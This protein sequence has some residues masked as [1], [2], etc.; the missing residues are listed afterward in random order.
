MLFAPMLLIMLAQSMPETAFEVDLWPGEGRPVFAASAARLQLREAPAESAGVAATWTGRIGQVLA[1]DDTRYRTVEVGRFVVLSP[2]TLTGR[3]L[4]DTRRLSREDY[5]SGTFGPARVSLRA[6]DQV[7]YLQYRAEGTCFVRVG[8]AA[9]E[10]DPCP[11]QD[12]RR[13]RLEAEPKTEWWIHVVQGDVCGWLL[14]AD[15]TVRV[16]RRGG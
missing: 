3:R 9:I 1:F 5:Y 13:F 7:E 4:G 12:Q 8:A 10:A 6:G 11:N 15:G 16:I 14:V 2:T